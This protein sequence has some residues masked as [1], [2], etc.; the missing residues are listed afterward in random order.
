MIGHVVDPINGLARF[1]FRAARRPI[2][3]GVIGGI[4][5]VALL[6]VWAWWTG[7]L[8]NADVTYAVIMVA[9][10][11]GSALFVGSR[12]LGSSRKAALAMGGIELDVQCIRWRR[13]DGSIG[14]EVSWDV[15][16][17]ATVEPR[18]RQIVLRRRD[19][20]P[21]LIGNGSGHVVLERFFELE[22]ALTSRVS[23]EQHTGSSDRS[24]ARR[25]SLYG[26]ICVLVSVGMYGANAAV[27]VW[28]NWTR[29]MTPMPILLAGMG[30]LAI[31]AG[32]RIWL[33]RGPLVSS[34][35][36]PGYPRALVRFLVVSVVADAVLVAVVNGLRP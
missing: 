32:L 29:L 23:V 8:R 7:R 19:S 34:L 18:N 15:L 33:G 26:V 5:V 12:I 14:F 27:G 2:W 13:G 3:A 10:T 11:F 25:V 30:L 31:I 17:G 22:R 35:Y 6:A 16:Q 36:S 9:C 4:A 1:E 20:S 24:A 28:L 21:V